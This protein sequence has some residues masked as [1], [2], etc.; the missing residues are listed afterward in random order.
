V[1]R[2]GQ[3]ITLSVSERDKAQLIE[4]A[5]E[6]GLTWGDRPNISK[7]VEAIARRQLLVFPNNDWTE[8]RINA[9]VKALHAL[10]DAGQV[11]EALELAVLLKE[12]SELSIPLRRE[13]EG[14]IENPPPPWR[15]EIERYIRRQ[16]PFQLAYRDAADRLWS[17]TIRHA[18]ITFHENRQYLDCWCEETEGN[19]DL[20]ELVHNWCL[21]LDRIPSEAAIVPVERQ[22]HSTLSQIEVEMHF[23]GGLAFAY[24]AKPTDISNDWL[25]DK[26]QVRQVVRPISSTF[27]FIREVLRYG[28]DCVVISPESVR[29]LLT[30]QLVSL[31]HQ[32]GLEI[33]D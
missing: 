12:R 10:T 28:S 20:P 8:T 23:F 33:Q 17:F 1:S 4:I 11:E 6:L 15:L 18:Q 21:R 2:K 9:L 22:W 13:I 29:K 32:Y 26:P 25:T 19:Q 31:C 14:F 16:Q 3:S 27:W 30:K 24:K 5:R 7:L